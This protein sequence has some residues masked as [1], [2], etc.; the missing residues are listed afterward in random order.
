MNKVQVG[1]FPSGGASALL[2]LRKFLKKLIEIR[3]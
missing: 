2:T 1:G 3:Y